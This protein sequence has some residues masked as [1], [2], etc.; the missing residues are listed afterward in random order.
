[1]KQK[2]EGRPL[3]K[4][5]GHQPWGAQ[6]K[7]QE[8]DIRGGEGERGQAVPLPPAGGEQRAPTPP[9]SPQGG[10]PTG[11]AERPQPHGA[12]AAAG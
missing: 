9:P 4:G 10:C 8:G 12:Q 7:R 5:Q 3:F 6:L 2:E 11:L 1:M